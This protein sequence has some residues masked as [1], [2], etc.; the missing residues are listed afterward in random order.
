L[1]SRPITGIFRAE[2]LRSLHPQLRSS[3]VEAKLDQC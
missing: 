3:S 2:F 1:V